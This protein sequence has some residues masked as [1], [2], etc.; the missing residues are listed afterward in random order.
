MWV[1]LSNSALVARRRPELFRKWAHYR[2][3]RV[4]LQRYVSDNEAEK[5]GCQNK[6]SQSKAVRTI[7]LDSRKLLRLPHR[8][9]NSTPFTNNPFRWTRVYSATPTLPKRITKTVRSE[10]NSLTLARSVVATLKNAFVV[11]HL[12]R[13]YQ[14]VSVY[15]FQTP[16]K[17][18]K[19]RHGLSRCS[20]FDV[21]ML[22]A[23]GLD[24]K[25]SRIHR[26]LRVDPAQGHAEVSRAHGLI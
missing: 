2:L 4:S 11:I 15:T 9:K 21:T 20:A 1:G 7:H 12:T 13:Y 17:A 6:G 16:N 23:G 3:L 26:E 10:N 8:N 19:V 5:S 24:R 22:F 18:D 14:V 25:V